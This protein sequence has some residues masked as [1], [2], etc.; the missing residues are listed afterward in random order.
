MNQFV[1]ATQLM[2]TR[3]LAILLLFIPHLACQ[4]PERNSLALTPGRRLHDTFVAELSV[5]EILFC[6][7]MLRD[8]LDLKTAARIQWV[9]VP[10]TIKNLTNMTKY[11]FGITGVRHG[12][13]SGFLAKAS[14]R[15]VPRCRIL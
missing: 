2:K 14:G 6:V 1:L 4:S 8:S 9:S 15:P 10:F 5:D 3:H 7:L 13:E 12:V 11:T